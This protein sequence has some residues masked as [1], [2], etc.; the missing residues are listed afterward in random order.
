MVFEFN[1][2]IIDVIKDLCVVYKFNLVFYEVFGSKGWESFC[3]ILEY[4]FDEYFMIVDVKW[5]DI[6]NIFCFYV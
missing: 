6:G 5:G 3:K 1:K 4:I 2:V